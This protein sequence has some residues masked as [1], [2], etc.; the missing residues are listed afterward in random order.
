M[1]VFG[2]SLGLFITP[3]GLLYGDV[4]KI[5]GPVMQI[6]MYFSPVVF[7]PVVS[8]TLFGKI[9]YFNPLSV[10]VI[11][12]RNSLLGLPLEQIAYFS[13]IFVSSLTLFA[14]ALV[15]FKITIPIITERIS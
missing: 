12:F 2:I 11:N 6:L 7:I 13:I 9:M 14:V 3:I 10:L 8:N 15:F 5:M 4:S 1:L